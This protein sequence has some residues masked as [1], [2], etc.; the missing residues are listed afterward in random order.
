MC[1]PRAWHRLT[2]VY[3]KSRKYRLFLQTCLLYTSS[4]EAWQWSS[5]GVEG[6]TLTEAEQPEVG[7]EI[8]LVLKEDTETDKYSEYL[9]EYTISG[10]V[11]YTH[12]LLH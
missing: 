9:D 8:T 4:E 1:L 3:L 2:T 11:S 7:T 10:P 12:L 6:Y 5:S